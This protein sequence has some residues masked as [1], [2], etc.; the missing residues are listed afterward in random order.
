MVRFSLLKTRSGAQRCPQNFSLRP[1]RS[2]W[3]L[4][5]YRTRSIRSTHDDAAVAA[6]EKI[7][8]STS[9]AAKSLQSKISDFKDLFVFDSSTRLPQLIPRSQRGEEVT[10]LGFLGKRREQSSTLTFCELDT[11]HKPAIQ[12]VSQVIEGDDDADKAAAVHAALRAIPSY[13]PV[14]CTGRLLE[15]PRRVKAVQEFGDN[16]GP[17]PNFPLDNLWDLKLTSIKPLNEFPKDIIVSKNAVWPPKQRHM[18]MRF[19]RML[20]DRIRFRDYLT[21]NV[22]QLLRSDRF[23][24]VETPMLFKSTPEGAREFLVPTRRAGYAYALPQS[25]QQYKQLLMAGGFRQYFQFARCFRDEDLRADRQPEFT[26]LDLEMSFASGQDVRVYV[27]RLVQ[28]I[29]RRLGRQFGYK[30][31]NGIRHPVKANP[32]EIAEAEA[33]MASK[34]GLLPP[35]ALY[36]WP[37]IPEKFPVLTYDEAM[38]RYGSDKPDLRIDSQILRIDD[39]VSP[40]FVSM[41][42]KLEN[43]AVEAAQFRL[44]GTAQ[45]NQAFIHKFMD[46][47]PKTPLKLSGDAT[48][49]VF[50]FDETK[51]LNGL[52]AFGHEAA[53]N[54]AA[55][56]SIDWKKLEHGDIVIVQARKKCA[57]PWRGLDRSSDPESLAAGEGQGGAAGFSSTH[58]PFTAPYGP[59]DFEL[60]TT[61]PL[62]AKADHYDLVCRGVEIGGGSR[63]IHVAEMQE[64]VMRDVLQMTDAGVGQFAHLLEALRAGCPPHAG[65]AFGWDR[66]V[67]I[68]SG[69][70]SVRDVI[71]FPKSMKGED[72]FVKSP[73]KMTDE[74]M[75]AYHLMPRREVKPMPTTTEATPT[76]EPVSASPEFAPSPSDIPVPGD[77]PIPSSSSVEKDHDDKA[78]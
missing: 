43:P 22:R 9:G 38:S 67:S 58:H 21:G 75:K 7:G 39:I 61:N 13:S 17:K 48:P 20:R 25:P 46:D 28:L 71:A 49:G 52:S 77:E 23:E 12:I 62:E 54:L 33:A 35:G 10:V 19:D 53:E 41:I 1:G 36:P 26:Q 3:Q 42:T 55:R 44:N 56:E 78:A 2:S 40:D 32:N 16:E 14:A 73:T 68:L 24:E 11:F 59:E 27:E 29:F 50:V 45:E 47:M 15:R 70:D 64:Y 66:F 51:P 74:Q 69:V 37:R 57:L 65:F 63:R 6:T 8:T 31:I 5:S 30:E 76:F 4:T 34:P 60:L 18:Q 72:L